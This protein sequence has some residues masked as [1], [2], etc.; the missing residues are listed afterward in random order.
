LFYA[1]LEHNSL[2][3]FFRGSHF[4]NQN[5]HHLLGEHVGVLW[6]HEGDDVA[7]GF[8][9]RSQRFA[10]LRTDALEY[11]KITNTPV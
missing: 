7:D 10:A 4:A 11:M 2:H 3:F 8:D 9:E 1:Y 6:L 5:L